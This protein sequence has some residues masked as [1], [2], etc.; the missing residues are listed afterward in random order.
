MKQEGG[1]MRAEH[2]TKQ[3]VLPTQRARSGIT[4]GHMRYVLGIGIAGAVTALLLAWFFL[5]R[6]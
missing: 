1:I 3:R 5:F 6:T 2:D 4:L